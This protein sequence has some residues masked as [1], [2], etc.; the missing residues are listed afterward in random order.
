MYLGLAN[1][2]F[3][4]SPSYVILPDAS[5]GNEYASF[6]TAL[7]ILPD[8]IVA[9]ARHFMADGMEQAGGYVDSVLSSVNYQLLL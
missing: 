9:S 4:S 2:I 8:A 5:G 7:Q 1:G 3:A 6:G